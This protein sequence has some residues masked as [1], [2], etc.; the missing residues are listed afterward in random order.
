LTDEALRGAALEPNEDNTQLLYDN[1]ALG[2]RLLHPRAWRVTGVRG[3]QIALD[4]TKGSG[5]LLTVEPAARV[6]TGAQFL[7]GSRDYWQK[8]GA[9]VR[10][11][12]P[13]RRVQAAPRELEQFALDVEAGGQRVLMDYYVARQAAGGA[14][15]AARLLEADRARLR[16]EVERIARS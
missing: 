10:A 12:A 1:P 16:R 13:P 4:E 6:P 11:A 15:L 8:Q 9:R 5:L 2:V 3:R 7:A 14:T